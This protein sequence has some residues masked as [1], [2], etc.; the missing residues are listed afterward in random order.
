M[1]KATTKGNT[2]FTQIA[3][4]LCAALQVSRKMH[5]TCDNMSEQHCHI[6]LG[7]ITDTRHNWPA[8]AKVVRYATM[9]T[10][11]M[12]GCRLPELETAADTPPIQ[13][14]LNEEATGKETLPQWMLG[15]DHMRV[16]ETGRPEH[17]MVWR[18][19]G[20]T[21]RYASPGF[22][23]PMPEDPMYRHTR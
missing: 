10:A 4:A 13:S 21:F 11:L 15:P 12:L 14:A 9:L 20:H 5:N 17:A 23:K 22:S 16:I 19:V 3:E 7:F 6:L 8:S 18:I 2:G 1:D